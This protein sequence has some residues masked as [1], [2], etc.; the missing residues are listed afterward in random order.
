MAEIAIGVVGLGV[1]G[2]P[3]AERL[4]ERS[5]ALQVYD[6]LTHLARN[7]M[8]HGGAGAVATAPM[9]AQ[10]CNIILVAT[11]DDAATRAV[12]LGPTGFVQHA[13]PG[14]IVIDMASDDPALTKEIA[15]AL[16]PRGA[17]LVDAP[18]IGGARE[19]AAGALMLLLSGQADDLARCR[20]VFDALAARTV[21]IGDTPGAARAAR[22]LARLYG[23][24]NLAAT[25]ETLLIGK[26][27]GIEPDA[28]MRAL[29]ALRESA[30]APPQTIDRE[31]LSGNFDSGYPLDQ[32]I[33][34]M[35][36]ALA[37]AQTRGTPAPLSR[38]AREIVGAARLHLPTA[39]DHTEIVRDLE[40][41][42]CADLVRDRGLA[43]TDIHEE[44]PLTVSVRS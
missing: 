40:A 20:P 29:D 8:V 18:V 9:I 4:R 36:C 34:D 7:Y 15:R 26:R 28:T 3:I 31:I 42:A 22:A 25:A 33:R 24:I 21:Q 2:A 41:N 12:T 35:D 32:L 44:P 1:A 11:D 43:T 37:A 19:A 10:L 30:G 5:L 13:R 16:V 27:F 17:A 39:Q 14:T 6:P 38:L 23:A